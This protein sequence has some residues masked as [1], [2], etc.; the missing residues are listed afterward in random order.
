[1]YTLFKDL[2]RHVRKL[3]I[4]DRTSEKK[5]SE[6]AEQKNEMSDTDITETLEKKIDETVEVSETLETKKSGMQE[7]EKS[8]TITKKKMS[9]MPEEISGTPQMEKTEVISETQKEIFET[10]KT[11]KSGILTEKEVSDVP[12][13]VFE[14]VKEVSQTPEMEISETP[15]TVSGTPKEI[16][17]TQVITETPEKEV[18]A[19]QETETSKMEISETQDT[20]VSETAKKMDEKKYVPVIQIGKNNKEI[21]TYKCE[22]C[23]KMYKNINHLLRHELVH[24]GEKFT[25]DVCQRSFTRKDTLTVHLNPHTGERSYA[26]TQ[27]PKSFY[28]ASNLKRHV[29]MHERKSEREINKFKADR[30]QKLVDVT[31]PEDDPSI[32]SRTYVC[33]VCDK[34]F[35]KRDLLVKHRQIHGKR[36]ISKTFK[37]F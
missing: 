29:K 21:R 19:T 35:S 24:K 3:H 25:C 1:M 17:E 37:W 12:T 14:V 23:G 13:E 6:A 7:N 32:T 30:K 28:T 4:A 16:S 27:C 8:A 5:I 20:E 31:V 26:C 15:Q 10:P 11:D 9:Q 18:S 22:E 33:K 36:G 2:T 34:A